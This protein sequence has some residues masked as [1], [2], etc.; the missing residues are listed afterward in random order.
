M[1]LYLNNFRCYKNITLELPDTGIVLLYGTS[2]IGK[3]TILKAIHFAITGKENK[4]VMYGE[5][6]CSVRLEYNN[7]IITRTKNPTHLILE[8]ENNKYEDEVAQNIIYKTYGQYFNVTSYIAQKSIDSFLNMSLQNKLEFFNSIA[9][10][11]INVSE[12]KDKVKTKIKERKNLVNDKSNEIRILKNQLSSCQKPVEIENPLGNDYQQKLK[13]ELQTRNETKLNLQQHLN[14]KTELLNKLEQLEKKKKTH[15][16][17]VL[18]KEK[19]ERLYKEIQNE[20]LEL[21][22]KIKEI[23]KKSDIY[24]SI[25]YLNDYL[26]KYFINLD[27]IQQQKKNKLEQL[28]VV[29][30]KIEELKELKIQKDTITYTEQEQKM[31]N[32]IYTLQKNFEKYKEILQTSPLYFTEENIKK[33]IF[34]S[35]T[36]L[37]NLENKIEENTNTKIEL[38]Q[39]LNYN[40][41]NK[42]FCPSCKTSL[43]IIKSDICIYN[44]EEEN[45]LLDDKNNATKIIEKINNENS[46]LQTQI[47]TLRKRIQ[48]FREIENYIPE[49][50]LYLQIENFKK[51]YDEFQNSINTQKSIQVN[52]QEYEK[53]LQVLEKELSYIVEPVLDVNFNIDFSIFSKLVSDDFDMEDFSSWNDLLDVDKDT[54]LDIFEYASKLTEKEKVKL[55]M[56]IKHKN[57]S[58]KKLEVLNP[59]INSYFDYNLYENI[60]TEYNK[61]CEKIDVLKTKEQAHNEIE[62]AILIYNTYLKE[63][64]RYESLKKQVDFCIKEEEVFIHSLNTA[65]KF[66]K[67]LTD[68][69]T[70]AISNTID[71][72]NFNIKQYT[73]LFFSDFQMQLTPY[74]ETAKGDKKTGIDIEI[75]QNGEKVSLDALS[76]GEFDRCLL[77]I[78]LA[79]NNLTNSNILLLDECLSSLNSEL[80]EDIVDVI[81][82]NLSNKLVLVT[83]HQAN[84]GIF[85]HVIDV[86]KLRV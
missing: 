29:N 43:S 39:K 32:K 23:E 14:L 78:F 30:K 12:L 69:E 53:N 59:S 15:E 49:L 63:L 28:S 22:E 24:K 7:M 75:Y 76:G 79:F 77:V 13:I 2:G 19:N 40:P 6:K 20:S 54:I 58:L 81:K 41:K 31:Y 25:N 61:C 8:Y 17:Q 80:V 65:E 51:F 71:N 16:D 56:Y 37:K 47:E 4:C 21:D 72:I 68:S 82:A 60:K 35:Q 1:K 42:L 84:T 38:S 70:I 9:L 55:N 44:Q 34:L 86:E 62:K 85:D 36:E 18:D 5:K 10:R 66:L 73:D 57:D 46:E 3:T 64:E 83:L 52:I 74:K 50:T 33:N 67:I 26:K 27:K 48:I 45:K 11:N